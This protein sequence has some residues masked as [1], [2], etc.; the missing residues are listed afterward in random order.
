MTDFSDTANVPFEI[1]L[2]GRTITVKRPSLKQVLGMLEQRILAKERGSMMAIA[3]ELDDRS[4]PEFLSSAFAQLPK[5]ADLQQMTWE[6]IG[7]PEGT[8]VVLLHAMKSGNGDQAVD[9]VLVDELI[10]A[11]PIVAAE[12]AA[13]LCGVSKKKPGNKPEPEETEDQSA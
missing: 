13:Y 1:V 7:S 4:K 3:K 6:S 2:S 9:E 8:A 10:S 12:W 11:E 5:G